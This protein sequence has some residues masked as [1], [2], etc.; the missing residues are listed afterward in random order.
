MDTFN[1]FIKCVSIVYVIKLVLKHNLF[2]HHLKIKIKFLGIDIEV[3]S[4][5]KS[6]PS[7]Q[8]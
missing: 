8:E 6:T 1:T 4:K 5:E 2:V 3:R 7:Q